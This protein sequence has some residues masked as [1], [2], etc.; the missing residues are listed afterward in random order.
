MTE[1]DL[2]IAENTSKNTH[3]TVA[4]LLLEERACRIVLD[5]PCGEGAFTKR[6]LDAGLDVHSADCQEIIRL[7]P[8]KFSIAD[9]SERLPYDDAMFDAVVCIDG[10]EHIER[11]FDFIK[12]CRRILRKGG[13]LIISTP[14]LLALRSRWRWLLTGFHQGEKSPLDEQHY[15]PLHHLSLVSFP[16]LRY[17]LHANDFRIS[18]IETNRV[19]FISWIYGALVPF[20]Y[21]MTRW[22]FNKEEK[23]EAVRQQNKEIFQQLFTMPIL[24]GETLIVKAVRQ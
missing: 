13:V 1:D 8:R 15:T 20:S 22:V 9:M 7:P 23:R 17:R 14:N 18:A 16:E 11:P 24:F 21:L 2:K 5:I 4:K 10:I 3:N 6:L 12:E 19:K